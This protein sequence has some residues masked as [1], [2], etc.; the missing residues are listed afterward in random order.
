[1]RV[2]LTGT[3]H[4]GGLAALRALRAAG[5]AP[6]A[7]VTSP[8]A[9]GA[10]SR[11]AAG[12]VRVPDPRTDPPAFAEA[13]ANAA[14]GIG[15]RAV[16]PG[17]EG[18]LLALAGHAD[19][20]GDDVALGAC[21]PAVTA[22]VTDKVAI[23]S[24]AADAGLEVLPARLMGVEGPP[25]TSGVRYPVA[26]KPLR[27]EVPVDGRLRRYETR[28]AD[29]PDSLVLALA[30]LPEGLG[31]VQE[32]AEG[33]LR[34][35]NGVAWQGEVVAQVHTAGLRRP[36]TVALD[37]ALAGSAAALMGQL[38]WSGIFNLR[39]VDS[40]ASCRLVDA[41][42]QL[43]TALELAVSAGANLPAIWVR[44]LLGERVEAPTYRVGMRH[45]R[46]GALASLSDPRPALTHARRAAGRLLPGGDGVLA[47]SPG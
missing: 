10:R 24:L 17:T 34:T 2:L 25:D 5:Y 16:L 30:A 26:V 43:Y 1:L 33:R 8:R 41:D 15:A 14:A 11:A 12:V 27:S 9:Y 4:P 7:A 45:R 36:E 19:R 21:A 47:R 22:A 38:G 37:H 39:F 28:R 23:L 3:E 6:W 32:Y 20:F 31:I 13:V 42:P 35:V 18:A 46:L 29:D 40:G 44:A